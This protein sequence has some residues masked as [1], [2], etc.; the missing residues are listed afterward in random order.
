MLDL[1][2]ERTVRMPLPGTTG[3][4][5][6]M[7]RF[8]FILVVAAVAVVAVPGPGREPVSVVPGTLEPRLVRRTLAIPDDPQYGN[9]GQDHF[10][11]HNFPAGWDVSQGSEDVVIAIVDSGVDYAHPD[12]AAS[13]WTNP[14]E[15]PDNDPTADASDH[16]MHVAGIA[17]AVTDNGIGVR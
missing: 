7:L 17:A 10:A 1:E 5:N 2:E 3:R 12:L 14:G 13:A 8:C 9:L 15:I 11:F 4:F 6:A 16:G